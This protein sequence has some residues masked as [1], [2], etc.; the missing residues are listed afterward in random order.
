MHRPPESLYSD[1]ILSDISCNPPIILF[2]KYFFRLSQDGPWAGGDR[3]V[4]FQLPQ[5]VLM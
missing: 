2:T 4:S 1:K 3:P 5:E